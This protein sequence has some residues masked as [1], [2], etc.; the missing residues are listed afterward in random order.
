MA[1][2]AG[3]LV[4]DRGGV[5]AAGDVTAS[6]APGFLRSD[7]ADEGIAFL[8][9]VLVLLVLLVALASAIVG[10]RPP[11]CPASPLRPRRGVVVVA[12]GL[13]VFLAGHERLGRE[14]A[15]A[16]RGAELARL[17]SRAEGPPFRLVDARVV[18]RRPTGFGEE[19][20][21]RDVR[22]RAG[23]APVPERLVVA[24][25]RGAPLER[26]RRGLVPVEDDEDGASRA[27]RLLWPGARVRIAVRIEPLRPT[28]NPGTPDRERAWARRGI[29]ARG[30]LVKPDWVVETIAEADLAGR[31][32]APLASL[33]RAARARTAERLPSDRP[34]AAL[35]R[36]LALGDRADLADA[37][38]RAFRDLGLTHL[39]SVSGLHIGF[40]ALPAAAAV[41]RLR[42]IRRARGRPVLG[43]GL[44]IAAGGLVAL[45]YA[46]WTGGSVP[47][48]RASLSFVLFG[49][50]RGLGRTLAPGPALTAVALV[51]LVSDPAALFD[52]GARF[53]F[54]AC[55]ALIAAGL[56]GTAPEAASFP[57]SPAGSRAASARGLPERGRRLLEA[58]VDPLRASLAVSIGL[59]PW[60]ELEGLPR[61]LPSPAINALAIPWA[62]FVVLP[63]SLVAC[64]LA[65]ALPTESGT[66]WAMDWGEG[67]LEGLV[68]PAAALER[69]AIGLA[70]ALSPVWTGTDR[71]GCL[72]WSIGIGAMGL[73]FLALRRRRLV[74]A[75]AIWIA[76]G[77][78]G[79][80]PLAVEGFAPTRP[81]VVFFDVGQADAALVETREAAWLIDS[82]PGSEAGT[83]GGTVLRALRAL[84]VERL[85]GLVITH[86][87]LDHRGG[88]LR[89][90]AAMPVAE[91]WLPALPRPDPALA[92]L[93]EAA[94]RRGVRVVHVAAGDRFRAGEDLELEVLWPPRPGS[95][96]PGLPAPDLERDRGSVGDDP[97]FGEQTRNERSIVLRA[98]I[99]GG[100]VLFMADVGSAVE[101]SLRS[102]GSRLASEV[103]KL[104][105]HGSR[106][107]S[108]RDF[109]VE[110]GAELAVVSA[111]CD[112]NRGL[113]SP[114]TLAR[115]RAGGSRILWTGRDGAVALGWSGPGARQVQGWGLERDCGVDERVPESARPP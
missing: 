110:V 85:E 10:P 11:G 89:L 1:H 59:L 114:D 58:V 29:G 100:S 23:E 84:G 78:L 87:D 28:R 36:A 111:P 106:R 108:S 45:C 35:V 31:I 63:C 72:P 44:P 67:V 7:I 74:P 83:G 65:L 4:A 91:L 24:W 71:A 96:R 53:S 21:L 109:L 50:A 19:V 97:V 99:G 47:A 107:S 75:A 101:A 16:R 94:R 70:S 14:L 40:V 2:A 90:I 102:R 81:R 115:V 92:T 25:T 69:S 112:A 55:A 103:L 61:A 86:G 76:L 3:I 98:S 79:L 60:V 46:A 77:S 66:G 39:L 18:A 5:L 38:R 56:W 17:A 6:I 33:R 51:L 26:A 68:W 73:G 57:A 64:A 113:P 52:P 80:E 43:F 15:C 32:E 88:S 37:S 82:G 95:P 27:D 8:A 22:A 93:A 30:R 104:G 12:V 62:G 54:T 42:V 34:G 9:L 41:G 49:A 20:E 13:L 48:L 105:H